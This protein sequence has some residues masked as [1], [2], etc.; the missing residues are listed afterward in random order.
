MNVVSYFILHIDDIFCILRFFG[1]RKVKMNKKNVQTTLIDVKF[2]EKFK[3]ELRIGLPRDK[4][5]RNCEIL[6]KKEPR[7]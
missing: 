2:D 1:Y 3:S 5:P 7:S 6:S 4:N